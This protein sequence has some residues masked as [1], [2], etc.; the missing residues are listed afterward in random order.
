MS[1]WS[2]GG[3]EFPLMRLSVSGRSTAACREDR[4]ASIEEVK[5]AVAQAA[6]LIQGSSA[7]AREYSGLLG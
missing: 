1:D 6:V 3:H 5:A 7:A 2:G 4:M